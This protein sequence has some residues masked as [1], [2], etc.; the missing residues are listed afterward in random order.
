MSYDGRSET[1]P[2]G[3]YSVLSDEPT[4]KVKRIEVRPGGRLSYQFHEYRAEHWFVVEGAGTVTLDGAEVRV[5]HGDTIDVE[6]RIPHRI[7]N[8]GD[9]RLVFIEVQHGD[10]FDETDIVRLEDDYGRA[11]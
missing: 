4:H 1:R 7:E 2:W 11:P 3:S 8:Q 5:S 10:S 6:R 9:Q